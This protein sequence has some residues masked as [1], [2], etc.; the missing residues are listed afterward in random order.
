MLV[1]FNNVK[2]GCKYNVM[3]QIGI[4]LIFLF[5]FLVIYYGI[6]LIYGILFG[7]IYQTF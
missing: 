3:F 5:G 2:W 1:H 6:L 4:Y 7:N